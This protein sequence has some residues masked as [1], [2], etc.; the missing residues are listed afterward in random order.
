[1]TAISSAE[2]LRL[3]A[4]D[5]LRGV[6]ILMVLLSHFAAPLIVWAP[7]STLVTTFGIGGVTLFFLL[8]GY[9]IF[10]NVRRQPIPVFLLRRASKLLPAYW[11]AIAAI[12]VSGWL[13]LQPTFSW[14]VYAANALLIPDLFTHTMIAGH[15]WTLVIEAKFYLLVA[16]QFWLFPTARSIGALAA[17]IALN[18]AFFL[19]TQ[20]GS[21]LLS[22]LPVF[23]IGVEILRWEEEGE[24]APATRRLTLVA[25]AVAT[26]TFLF[27][28]YEN[29]AASV[30]A[31]AGAAVFVWALRAEWDVAW[32]RFLGRISYSLYLFHVIVGFPVADAVAGAGG[33]GWTAMIAGMAASVAVGYLSFRYIEAP[34]VAFGRR[35]ETAFALTR[36]PRVS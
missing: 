12:V 13:A 18:A 23:Y 8:S 29:V 2:T 10:R 14:P 25:A 7:A 11:L 3:P 26:S 30:Y 6:A 19:V 9:L 22:F 16:L 4:L 24:A 36:A 15:L 34:G 21:V 20:R 33:P 27:V 32:L 31:I 17:L 28:A 1:M 5:T 35:L